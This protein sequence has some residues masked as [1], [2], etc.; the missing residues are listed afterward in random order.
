MKD[1]EKD[2]WKKSTQ[3]IKYIRSTIGIPLILGID[4]T[5]TLCWY[6]DTA[7]GVHCDMK[8]R[9][10]MMMTMGQGDSRSNSNKHKL[11]TKISTEVE[12]V[13]IDD[14]I[15]FIIWSGYLLAEQA[16]HV[17]DNIFYQDNHSTAKLENIA[18]ASSSKSTRHI[19]GRYLFVT[20]QIKSGEMKIQ[21]I[22]TLY[23]IG[24]YFTKPL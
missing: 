7:F 10:G 17:R 5:N 15:S 6:V 24:D 14:E 22:P 4:D 11:K 20:D 3:V 9:T 8:S 21:Y 1:P 18:H 19:N 13:G 2:D 12:L 16:Y 23:M